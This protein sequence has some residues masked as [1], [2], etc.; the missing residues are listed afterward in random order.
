M[1]VARGPGD[2]PFSAPMTGSPSL[3]R[4][5]LQELRRPSALRDWTPRLIPAIAF[6]LELRQHLLL[7]ALVIKML[8]RWKSNAYQLY[9][10][11]PRDQLASYSYRLGCALSTK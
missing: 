5:L 2:G 6:E 11:T 10:K 7:R 3:D 1:L 4:D 9:I 8:G